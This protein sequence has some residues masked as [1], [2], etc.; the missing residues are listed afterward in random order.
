MII[1]GSKKKKINKKSIV[2]YFKNTASPKLKGD[3]IS[4]L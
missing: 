2:N 4:P 1:R 3:M